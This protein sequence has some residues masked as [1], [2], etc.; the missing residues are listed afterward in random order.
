MVTTNKQQ[1]RNKKK[2]KKNNK[3]ATIPQLGNVGG[4]LRD[5]TSP[6]PRR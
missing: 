5:Y 1:A 6:V 2:T 3:L 4:F